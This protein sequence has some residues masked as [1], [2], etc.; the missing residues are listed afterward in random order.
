MRNLLAGAVIA[1]TLAGCAVQSQH[2]ASLSEAEFAEYAG[3]MQEMSW[4][5][6]SGERRPVVQPTVVPMD[7][8][9][10]SRNGCMAANQ[11]SDEECLVTFIYTPEDIGYLSSS[12]LDYVY[13]YYVS[14]LVPCLAL[15]RL[16]LGFA[17]TRAEFSS[18]GWISWDPY[19][20]LGADLPP[21]RT[22]AI[23][24]ACPPYPPM[25]FSK[26]YG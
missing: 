3:S 4:Y 13:D 23:F 25:P 7:D 18:A 11:I 22:E 5:E 17:P 14:E 6:V 20:E 10:Q 26:A 12:E 9:E 15:Q 24:E 1:L 2:P 21:S 19:T 8:M 16:S